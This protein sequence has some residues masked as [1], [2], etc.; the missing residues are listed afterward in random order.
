MN[1]QLKEKFQAY[2]DKKNA[3]DV[4][5]STMYYDIATIA[6]K[7]GISY[8][9]RMLAI[10][11]GEA[12]S[13][14]TDSENIAMIEALAA[15][16][17]NSDEERKELELV[18]RDLADIRVLPKELYVEFT[19]ITAESQ[20]AWEEAKEKND[21]ALFKPHLI[22]VIEKQKEV[23]SY[24][25][26]TISDYDYMLDRYQEGLSMER[27]DEFFDQIK[28]ELLPFI[29]RL[30]KEGK[31]IDDAP[32]F[33]PYDVKKQEEFMEI[34]LQHLQRDP[35]KCYV[36]VSEHPFTDFYSANETRIT[37]HY[38]EDNVMSAIFSTIH[39][40]GHA[41]YGLH[42]NPAY[43]GT[44]LEHNIGFAMHES[45]SRFMENNI[46]RRTSFW[47]PLYPKLQELF[48]EQLG[49]VDLDSFMKMINVSRPSFI[50]TEADELTY[51]IHILIRYEL[52][53]EIFNGN[54]DYDHL[55]TMWND[56]Y[57]EYLGIRP[58]NDRDGILQ[59]MHW[60]AANLGYFP[61]YA[62]GSAYAAQFYHQMDKDMDIDT[63]LEQG[64][65]DKIYAWLEKNIHRFGAYKSADDIMRD[66]TGESFDVSY[67]INYLKDKFSKLYEI[68]K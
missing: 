67:Y 45:Q 52:E 8:R 37:T 44:T 62:L 49:S 5:L 7:D 3:Y 57:E 18:L 46:G 35:K 27:Y 42:V 4:A 36:T 53:K 6:P 9:N 15:C 16:E 30:L 25:D 38:Y 58:K 10:L 22:K 60:G 17:D 50:R 29:Q 40:Y 55:D 54:V 20:R 28:K 21:Y 31:Q 48:P 12:F 41:N 13:H 63:I 14:E 2:K 65:F 26:K 66:T 23:L 43:E 11:S 59:D 56:K 47:K 64:V 19:Q 1:T 61:T 33:V 68:E 24:V 51:P 39:E 32:L 34:L